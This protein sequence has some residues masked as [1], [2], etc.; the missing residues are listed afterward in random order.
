MITILGILFFFFGTIIG[1]FL[2]VVVF[3]LNTGMT[4]G[5]RSRCFGC[6]KVLNWHELV[7]VASFIAQRGKCTG[8][9]HKISSQYIVVEAV[10][11]VVFALL[12]FKLLPFFAVLP[13]LFAVL[14][15]IYGLIF[16]L[17]IVI[18]VYDFRHMIIPENIVWLFN[19]F[20][21][22]SAFFITPFGLVLHLPSLATF[23][24]AACLVGF[25][26]GLWF[27]SKGKMMGFGDAKLVVGI[28]FLLSPLAAVSAVLFSFWIGAIVAII[29][30]FTLPRKDTLRLKIPFAPF[31]ALGTFFV[32]I[33][34]ITVDTFF[35]VFM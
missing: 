4:L 15:I 29:I 3:R 21:I 12:A 33:S 23:V 24:T 27:L 2:N 30:L 25:F 19:G 18:V 10:T 31:L 22:F 5:G 35:G 20:A 17:L 8:C 26:A 6:K 32:F 16:S 13:S 14:Y 34:G 1:S 9:G 11:G 28:G 7:P